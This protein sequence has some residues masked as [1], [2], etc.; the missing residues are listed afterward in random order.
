MKITDEQ[1][2]QLRRSFAS[3]DVNGDGCIDKSELQKV[4][5][6]LGVK[7]VNSK[8]AEEILK[9]LDANGDGSVSFGEFLKS[10]NSIESLGEVEI[11]DIVANKINKHRGAD[12]QVVATQ[13][14]GGVK[15]GNAAPA[16]SAAKP[17]AA[18]PAPS[19]AKP[20]AAAPAPA[21]AAPAPSAA[22]PPPSATAP[23]PSAKPAATV[24]APVGTA[25]KAGGSPHKFVWKYEGVKVDLAGDFTAWGAGRLPMHRNADGH[26]EIEVTLKPGEWEYRFV[27]NDNI[28]W[29]YDIALPHRLN[30]GSGY[31]NNYI[32]V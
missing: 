31:I 25:S 19:A 9:E 21:A 3:Y 20:A 11:D 15:S 10:L 2:Q 22:A 30:D 13:T 4:L 18:A 5:L 7:D 16:P 28:E 26:F 17:A 14:T 29:Y 6:D 27:V 23:A 24:S 8:E 1:L 12:E 32:T